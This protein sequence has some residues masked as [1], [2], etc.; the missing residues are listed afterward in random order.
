MKH[1][2]LKLHAVKTAQGFDE[3]KQA[4]H[5]GG[6]VAGNARK[7]LEK[8][9]GKKISTSQNYREITTKQIEEQNDD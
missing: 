9:S 4:A 5:E 3:N 7:E 6:Q 8:K 1:P 2:P